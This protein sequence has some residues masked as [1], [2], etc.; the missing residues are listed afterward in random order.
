MNFPIEFHISSF[1][2]SAHFIFESL[3]YIIGF[4]YYKYLRSNFAQNEISIDKNL[5]LITGCI[6]GAALGSKLL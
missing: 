1:N 6:F 3:G 4:R 2:I 5:W